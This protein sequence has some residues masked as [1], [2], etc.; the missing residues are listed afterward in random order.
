MGNYY[1]K[2]EGQIKNGKYHGFGKLTE[3]SESKEGNWENGKFKDGV[4]ILP[5]NRIISGIFEN[6]VLTN[7]KIIHADGTTMEGFWKNKKLIQGK[8]IY[9]N[10]DVNVY[11]N[12]ISYVSYA[13]GCSFEGPLTHYQHGYKADGY[14]KFTAVDGK[15]TS[16]EFKNGVLIIN[17]NEDYKNTEVRITF[18]ER[19][20]GTVGIR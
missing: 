6:N 8:I 14:G 20:F 18:K 17:Y 13:S 7:G 16:G 1:T 3:N 12:G 4:W 2:Y 15:K 11:E 9:P 10:G 19:Y 5:G